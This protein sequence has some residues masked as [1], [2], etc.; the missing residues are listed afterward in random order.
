MK[1]IWNFVKR[2]DNWY[3]LILT[4]YFLL[5]VFYYYFGAERQLLVSNIFCFFLLLISYWEKKVITKTLNKELHFYSN[6]YC[7]KFEVAYCQR[8]VFQAVCWVLAIAIIFTTVS[9]ILSSLN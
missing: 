2:N 1:T 6:P 9:G 5:S 7:D 3:K 8:F 4:G